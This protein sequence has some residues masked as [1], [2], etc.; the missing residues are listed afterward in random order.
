MPMHLTCS[1]D[2]AASGWNTV[3]REGISI[4]HPL[5]FILIGYGNPGEEDG[6]KDDDASAIATKE[7]KEE[8]GLDPS[9]VN[10]VTIFQL[11]NLVLIR[12]RMQLSNLV[13]IRNRMKFK[14]CASDLEVKNLSL[15]VTLVLLL[16]MLI[17]C[18]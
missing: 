15:A 8:I 2:C 13:L 7:A 6:D 17:L 14:S 11:S 4:S 9:L 3:E 10:V 18:D 12:N 16:L 5:R 1:T